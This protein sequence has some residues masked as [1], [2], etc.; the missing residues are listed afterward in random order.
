MN[1][2]TT[3]SYEIILGLIKK[4]LES[5]ITDIRRCKLNRALGWFLKCKPHGSTVAL[6]R[7]YQKYCDRNEILDI[8]DQRF[9][10]IISALEDLRVI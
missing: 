7:R 3:E 10:T 6:Y 1:L 2:M 5:D 9:Y 8:G 4:E